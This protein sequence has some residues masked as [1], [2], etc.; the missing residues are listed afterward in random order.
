MSDLVWLTLAGMLATARPINPRRP[1]WLEEAYLKERDAYFE[2][3]AKEE[4]EDERNPED[5][6]TAP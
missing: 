5:R 3:L 1:R 4:S 6:D 2:A